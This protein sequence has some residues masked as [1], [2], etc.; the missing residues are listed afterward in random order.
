MKI[1]INSAKPKMLVVPLNGTNIGHMKSTYNMLWPFVPC[2]K[3]NMRS[4]Q[5]MLSMVPIEH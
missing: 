1:Y 2:K 5:A 4:H 3:V